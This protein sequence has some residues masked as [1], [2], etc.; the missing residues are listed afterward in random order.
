MKGEKISSTIFSGLIRVLIALKANALRSSKP[1]YTLVLIFNYRKT[2]G[3]TSSAK[4]YIDLGEQP[5]LE[6]FLSS[7]SDLRDANVMFPVYK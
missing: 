4:R 6:R 2:T 7:D 3:L 1:H 5:S